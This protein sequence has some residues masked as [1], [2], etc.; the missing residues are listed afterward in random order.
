MALT[1]TASS[2]ANAKGEVRLQ[3]LHDIYKTSKSANT[4]IMN[5][6]M[7]SIYGFMKKCT[8][9][10]VKKRG[11]RAKTQGILNWCR[12][13]QSYCDKWVDG[14]SRCEESGLVNDNSI[15][16]PLVIQVVDEQSQRPTVTTKR[17]RRV[18]DKTVLLSLIERR[19]NWK[20]SSHVNAVFY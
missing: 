8:M 11:Q 6:G 19:G 20:V 9:S 3:K 1:M 12:Y 5:I 13:W 14:F 10:I 7:I 15:N 4:V 16:Y 2:K 17:N 18:G